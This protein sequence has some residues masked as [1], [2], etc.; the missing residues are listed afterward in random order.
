MEVTVL[1]THDGAL[2]VVTAH[3]DLAADLTR[4]GALHCLGHGD[5]PA[6]MLSDGLVSSLSR[7]GIG[8]AQPGDVTAVL[9]AVCTRSAIQAACIA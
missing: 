3:S 1:E 4:L 6:T 2:V 7:N 9:R 8:V 5:A